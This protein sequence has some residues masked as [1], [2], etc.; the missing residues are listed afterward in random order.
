MR[1]EIV[2]V[3]TELLMG[4][5][6]NTNAQ[7]LA[8]K[9]NEL[10]FSHYVQTVIGDNPDRLKKV[11]QQAEQRADIIIYTGGLGPT[12][13]DLTKQTLSEYLDEPLA[14][15]EIGMARIRESF[16]G[17]VMTDNNFAMGLTFEN[18]ETFPND[19]GQALGTSIEKNG[20]TYILLPG[21]PREMKP[22]FT[23]YVVEFL[24]EKF[25]NDAIFTSRY[26][27]Y[28]GIGESQ[29]ADTIDDLVTSQTNPTIATYFGDFT[30]TV[31]LTAAG[32]DKPTN[33]QLLDDI[34]SQINERLGDYYFGQ[35]EELALNQEVVRMLKEKGKTIAFAESFTG[36]LAAKKIVDVSG[37]SAILNGSVVAYTGEAKH[38]ILHV[39]QETID[40]VGMVSEET[41]IQM[42]EN[43]Q[44]L[45]QSDIGVS[46]T[47]VAGPDEMEGKPVGT[48]YIG[49]AEEGKPTK[50]LTPTLRGGRHNLQYRA[51]YNA[52]FE[53]IKNK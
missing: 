51:V 10:G 12:R 36:G 53:L 34:A 24:L 40:T 13:D 14:T 20:K 3:G 31:R 41:A 27:R 37:S 33:D 22:M 26:L 6:A 35:G 7:F 52:Y 46:F 25:Q 39:D 28:F 50:V 42:A 23:N 44:K 18:G 11:T 15:D 21:P 48:I 45:F 29:L 30:V 2:A 16:K 5:I 43:T 49:I 47:G 32:K 38:N 19:T 1:V 17:R 8:R 9:L 4:Q